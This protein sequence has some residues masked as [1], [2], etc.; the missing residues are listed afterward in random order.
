VVDVV[1]HP[2]KTLGSQRRSAWS[3]E[4]LSGE[5]AIYI[6]NLRLK[7]KERKRPH[8]Q[9]VHYQCW[10]IPPPGP[11]R[12]RLHGHCRKPAIGDNG[13]NGQADKRFFIF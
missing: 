3:N 8:E 12:R 5:K 13:R 9:T 2:K 4:F 7:P 1:G 11:Y 10:H 6:T